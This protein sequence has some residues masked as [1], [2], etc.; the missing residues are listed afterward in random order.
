MALGPRLQRSQSLV[1][2][3]QLQQSI[4]LLQMSNLELSGFI[5][6]EIENNPL[7]D[8]A[9]PQSGQDDSESPNRDLPESDMVVSGEPEPSWEP[10][11]SFENWGPGGR[12]QDEPGFEDIASRE[13]SLRDH[14]VGQINIDFPD[15]PERIIALKLAAMLDENGRLD[16]EIDSIAAEL[17][18]DLPLVETILDRCQ[19][20]DPPGVFA[21]SL[22][23]CLRLQLREGRD[24]DPVTEAIIDNLDL[25][26]RGE[27]VRLQRLCGVKK[28]Q[29]T[30]A[31]LKI[32]ALNPRP[33]SNFEH[34]V[35]Q[36]AV[37]DVL[38]YRSAGGCR[39]ELNSETLPRILVNRRYYAKVRRLTTSRSE[40]EF[41][42]DRLQSANWLVR[43]LNQRAETILKVATEIV[44]RQDVFFEEGISHLQPLTLREVAEAIGMHESTV[45]RV[46]SNKY[47]D[48]GRGV[49]ALKYFFN[50]SLGEEG[51]AHSAK[52]VRFRIKN[53]IDEE[54]PEA[55]L[56]DDRIA[57]VLQAEGVSIARRTVAKYREAMRIP[58]SARRRREKSLWPGVTPD[59]GAY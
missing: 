39:I 44:R 31:V 9:E 40:L 18:C 49:F 28:E 17:R 26:A 59:A 38:V 52:A 11:G 5:D 50:V 13:T 10:A 43:A 8:R 21:R 29:L 36:V 37:P 55:V 33:G 16:G 41:L 20:L 47:V 46:T 1:M 48:T 23:E 32:K 34:E 6:R 22:C 54:P 2:T 4:K 30:R 57:R 53:L 58:S 35:A 14:I 15:P 27:F 25:L 3:P 51:A 24:L 19:Q 12:F 56:S 7:I 45:S 42:S